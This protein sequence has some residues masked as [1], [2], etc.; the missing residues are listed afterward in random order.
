MPVNM[1]EMITPEE[2]AKRTGWSERR[3]REM[4]RRLGACRIVGNRMLLTQSDV[5]AILEASK[6]EPLIPIAQQCGLPHLGNYEDLK[7]LLEARSKRR[8]P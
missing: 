4:A 7:R 5:D 2:F 3:L 6:P 1:P 8:K